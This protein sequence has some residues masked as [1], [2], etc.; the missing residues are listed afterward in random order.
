LAERP[1]A[2]FIGGGAAGFFGAIACAEANPAATVTLLEAARQPLTKVRISGGGR[3]N[4]THHCFDPARLVQAYPR[5]HRELRGPFSRFQPRDTVAWFESRGVPLKTEADGRMFPTTDSS[6]TVVRCLLHQAQQAGVAWQAGTRVQAVRS[7]AETQHGRFELD[8]KQGGPL[9]CDRL[10]IATGSSACGYR[11]ARHLGHTVRPP[12][13]SLFSFRVDDARLAELA[14]ITV[15]PVRL[16]LLGH[17]R[18]LQPQ[19]GSLL[20]AHWGLSGP[21]ALKLSAWGARVL[22]DC[23]YRLPLAI[24]W[25]PQQDAETLRQRLL[26]L[27]TETPQ[28][29]L[30][31]QNA[32]ALPKR[33]WRN[34]LQAAGARPTQRWAELSKRHLERLV[35]ELKQGH[36][37]IGGRRPYADEFVTCGG[38]ERKEI[39]FKTMASRRCP[40]LYWAGEAIDIDAITGGFNFQNAWTTGWL[41][42]R[43]M[44]G[45]DGKR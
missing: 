37:A 36:Y 30:T 4:V 28:R 16:R 39:D 18:S 1:H 43:A 14:G 44:A 40:G 23:R 15:D 35:A 9:C 27:K 10:A 33:L 21:A 24:D 32:V 20:I 31:R 12:V 22:H 34:L 29:Q 5:G 45:W 6:E 42:G 17:G 19:T 7:P 11:W 25:V 41:A 13:P 3:C 8:L 2:I 26:A 38:V